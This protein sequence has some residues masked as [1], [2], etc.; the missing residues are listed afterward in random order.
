MVLAAA[1]PIQRNEPSERLHETVPEPSGVPSHLNL[2]F[3]A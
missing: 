3:V 1:L 2:K